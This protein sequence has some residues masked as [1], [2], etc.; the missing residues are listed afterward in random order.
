MPNRSN[1]SDVVAKRLCNTCGG[2]YGI[3][4]ADAIYFTETKGGHY[5]PVIDETACTC[6]GLCMEIC[7]GAGFGPSLLTALPADP[8]EGYCLNAYVGK[9]LNGRIY[10]NA[11]SGGIASAL[12][13]EALE[14]HRIRS[15][16]TVS[17]EFGNPPRPSVK[18]SRNISEILQGQKSK[19]CPVPLLGFLRELKKEDCPIA[20]VGTSCQIHG[21]RNVLEKLPKLRTTVAFTVGLVCDRVLTYAA[22]DYLVAKSEIDPDTQVMLNFRD[23][24]VSD[25]PGDVHVTSVNGQSVIMPSKT[26]IR[27]KDYFTPARCRLC[28]DKMNVFSDITVGDPHGISGLERKRGESVVIARTEK[29]GEIIQAA[30]QDK[31]IAVRPVPYDAVLSGQGIGR[32]REQ[33]RGYV[34]A[35]AQSGHELP[36]YVEMVKRA[37]P[38]L[39]RKVGYRNGLQHALSLDQFPTREDLDCF[40]D[41]M[42][43]KRGFINKLLFPFAFVKK[44]VKKRFAHRHETQK[45]VNE[46]SSC[47]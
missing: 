19:Y 38:L 47:S 33:W 27:I 41:R 36:N 4:P 9:A 17:M 30:C 2:C 11:Q 16:I 12:L 20:V 10:D 18:F 25:Y 13:V 8:F 35:W 21:L 46:D 6:C 23:K 32:K 3:C 43:K 24:S 26:R 39:S 37:A 34:D 44:T 15:A 1:I 31:A 40:V 22:L 28:F 14:G 29:G 42:L 45:T 5:F 7:P